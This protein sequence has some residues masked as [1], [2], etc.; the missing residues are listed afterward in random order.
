VF[1]AMART[2]HGSQTAKTMRESYAQNYSL[3]RQSS[4]LKPLQATFTRW[5]KR[6]AKNVEK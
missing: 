1:K 5:C 6:A 3:K 2:K 4:L